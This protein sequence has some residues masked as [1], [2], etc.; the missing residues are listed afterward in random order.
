M[1]KAWDLNG[2]FAVAES[3]QMLQGSQEFAGP[4]ERNEQEKVIIA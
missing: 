4:L 1:G 3:Y 2:H